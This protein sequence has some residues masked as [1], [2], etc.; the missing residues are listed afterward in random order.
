[1]LSIHSLYSIL[2]P[3]YSLMWDLVPQLGV[4]GGRERELSIP[5][6]GIHSKE[7]NSK[8]YAKVILSIPLCG[9]PIVSGSG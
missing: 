3:F 9:I 5:L 6:C 1:M 2:D 8:T 7:Q 4:L